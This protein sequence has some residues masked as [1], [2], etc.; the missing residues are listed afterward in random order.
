[1]TVVFVQRPVSLLA[2]GVAALIT[3]CLILLKLLFVINKE[4]PT[5]EIQDVENYTKPWKLDEVFIFLGILI[6]V[7]SMGSSS[8]VEEEH[9]IWHFLTSTINLL[10]FRKAIQSFD[11]NKAVDDLISLGKENNT[12]GQISLLFLTLFSGRI[13]KG[14]HQGGVNWTNIPDIST[15]LEQAG[16]QYINLIKIASCIIIIMLGIFLLFLLESKTKVVTVIGLSL[17]M[18]GLLVLQHF[19]KH[20][21]MSAS[22]NKD[23]TL[24]VQVFYAI[25]G[26]TTVT[27]VLVL[28]WIMPIK[29]REMCSKWNLYMSASVPTKVHNMTPIFV[30]K[31]SLHVMGCVY[32]T[33]WCLLQLLLQRPINAMPLLLLN[34][35]ILAYML[36]FSSCGSHH[37]Q[38]VEVSCKICE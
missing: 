21:D 11:L 17:L 31:D 30:L 24:S 16:S 14:W 10:F 4:V 13:L 19:M 22:Y 36:A 28:P 6:L 2:F 33:S 20:Q 7:I 9:Y 38:W 29:T 37:K 26:I 1:M 32:I 18:S 27:V 8:M 34:V 25:L 35:Q 12:S 5:L 15:W 23:A 3:S